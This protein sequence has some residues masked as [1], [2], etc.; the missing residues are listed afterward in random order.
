M[1]GRAVRARASGGLRPRALSESA[2]R[3]G[4]WGLSP[5]AAPVPGT[6]AEPALWPAA[7]PAVRPAAA[8]RRPA[9][10]RRR[11]PL[12]PAGPG[13]SGRLRA[14]GPGGSRWLGAASRPAGSQLLPER[15]PDADRS[16]LPDAVELIDVG[17]VDV[18]PGRRLRADRRQDAAPE[19][20]QGGL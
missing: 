9:A 18:R 6:T 20:A 1:M 12:G 10:A 11:L 3:T 19:D 2:A 8:L 15:V 17:S 14:A 5:T 13:R 16:G 4:A 7:E